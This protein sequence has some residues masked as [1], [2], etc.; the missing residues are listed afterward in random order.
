MRDQLKN[1][2]YWQRIWIRFKDGDLDAF[3]EI[4]EE[5]IDLMYDYG[6]KITQDKDLVKDCIQDLFVDL[7]KYGE[8]T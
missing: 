7:Y 1:R 5:Y 3:G 4:Y 2:E 8:K 6:S